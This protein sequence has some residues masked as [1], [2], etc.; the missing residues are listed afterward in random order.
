MFFI[1]IL[2]DWTLRVIF[3]FGCNPAKSLCVS[4]P[5]T[6]NLQDV[7][8]ISYLQCTHTTLIIMDIQRMATWSVVK[9][10]GNHELIVGLQFRIE[11]WE[12]L[13]LCENPLREGLGFRVVTLPLSM[14]ITLLSKLKLQATSV[15]AT[16]SV[17]F[18]K[19]NPFCDV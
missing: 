13:T 17:W 8:F 1:K 18:L 5:I 16:P 4:C 7:I 9:C 15:Q 3:F 14:W 12:L 2:F 19:K 6:L 11:N 10:I